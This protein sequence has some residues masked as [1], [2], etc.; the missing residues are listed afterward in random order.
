VPASFQAGPID[1]LVIAVPRKFGDDRGYFEETYKGSE[2][3]ANGIPGP[4]LQD[5]H[6]RSVRGVLRGLHFQRAPHAQGKLV[7]VLSGSVWDVAV[8]LRN[9]SPSFTRWF[10]MELSEENGKMLFIPPGFAHGFVTLSGTADFMYKCTA[11]YAPSADGGIRW[12]DPDIAI[13]WPIND[14][15]VSSKD[16]V[17]PFLRDLPR[18]SLHNMAGGLS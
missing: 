16:E 8:D 18:D 4:F 14:I 9:E 2:Y 1:G 13:T 11:E 10:G 3:A 12:N 7:R 15:L 6:S 5:N 17:L